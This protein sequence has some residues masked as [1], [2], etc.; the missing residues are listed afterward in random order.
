M[1]R[2]LQF[3]TPLILI[4]I[5]ATSCS[6]FR[7]AGIYRAEGRTVDGELSGS[8]F[9]AENTTYAIGSLS[10]DWERVRSERGDLMFWNRKSNAVIT[11]DSVCDENKLKYNLRALSE[12]LVTGIKDKELL[13]RDNVEIDGMEALYSQYE[14]MA[15]GMRIGVS[16]VVLKS[17]EC[18]YDMSYSSMI[19][20]FNHNL[21][22]FLEFASDFRV[23][24]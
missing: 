13:L 1:R 20:N 19:G 12:S 7:F 17:G 22:E 11:V 4:V 14:A 10:G 6:A 3:F 8:V 5:I 18:I 15:D 23:I 2:H 16:T 24:N 21:Q 9:T